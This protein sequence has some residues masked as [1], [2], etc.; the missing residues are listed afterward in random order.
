MKCPECQSLNPSGAVRCHLC[1]AELPPDTS[2]RLRASSYFGVHTLTGRGGK[3]I[4]AVLDLGPNPWVN[5]I[6]G[7]S[8]C[9]AFAA[10]TIPAIVEEAGRT[11][12]SVRYAGPGPSEDGRPVLY[13][14]VDDDEGRSMAVAGSLEVG[15]YEIEAEGARWLGSWT[16]TLRRE[17]FVARSVRTSA[18]E[19]RVLSTSELCAQVG[20]V[21]TEG[22][23]DLHA[24]LAAGRM[25]ATRVELHADGGEVLETV[26]PW[27][28]PATD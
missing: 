19:G 26:S 13:L 16:T 28:R 1:D 4:R 2:A 18:G 3:P 15:F 9:L 23:E 8:I 17:D 5:F 22:L 20:P 7:A 6:V 25:V 27:L 14:I 21:P 12:S 24:A 11:P 10:S